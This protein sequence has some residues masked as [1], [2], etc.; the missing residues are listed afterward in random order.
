MSTNVILLKPEEDILEKCAELYFE[1]KETIFVFPSRRSGRYLKKIIA[2]KYKQPFIPPETYSIEEWILK[3]GE[4]FQ[5]KR[6]LIDEL[7]GS[8][9]IEKIIRR[10]GKYEEIFGKKY[11]TFPF[12]WLRE[13]YTLFEELMKNGV[14]VEDVQKV[15]L[16]DD[17]KI[18]IKLLENLPL[19]YHSYLDYL[20]EEGLT[21][22]GYS[23]Y[24]LFKNIDLLKIHN[25]IFAGLYAPTRVETVILKKSLS[26]KGN[27]LLFQ[28]TNYYDPLLEKVLNEMSV[29]YSPSNK[30]LPTTTIYFVPNLFSQTDIV[31]EI[32]HSGKNRIEEW[33]D[34]VII[35]PE[36][37]MLLPLL[38]GALSKINSPF[39]ITMGYP[40]SRTSL[41][42]LIGKLFKIWVSDQYDKVHYLDFISVISSP[43]IKNL[44]IKEYEP[45][46]SRIFF[47]NLRQTVKD[48]NFLMVDPLKLLQPSLLPKEVKEKGLFL[49]EVSEIFKLLFYLPR[50]KETTIKY[51]ATK[52]IKILNIIIEKS[53]FKK[54]IFSREY[55]DTLLKSIEQLGRKEIATR[56]M[57]INEATKII[58]KELEN[59]SVPFS[60]TP[61]KGIQVMGLLE[62]RNLKFRRVI[63]LN[64][65]EDTLPPI[66]K[67]SPLLPATIRT[68]LNLTMDLD[69][70]QYH[71]LISKHHF[72]TLIES[73]KEVHIIVVYNDESLTSRYV[74]EILWK[75]ENKTKI[76]RYSFPVTIKIPE[77]KI[78]INKTASI[79]KNLLHKPLSPTLL[80]TYIECPLKFYFSFILKLEE[81]YEEYEQEKYKKHGIIAHKILEEAYKKVFLKGDPILREDKLEELKSTINDLSEKIVRDEFPEEKG[82]YTVR[83]LI[84]QEVMK[85][86]LNSFATI[87]ININKGKQLIELERKIEI[88]DEIDNT[89]FRLKGILDRLQKDLQNNIIEIIDYKTSSNSKNYKPPV[90]NLRKKTNFW[91]TIISLD[92]PETINTIEDDMEFR[93]VFFDTIKNIQLPLYAYL[94]R[95]H[96]ENISKT[97]ISLQIKPTFYFI[98][99]NT[100]SMALDLSPLS[101]SSEAELFK[102]RILST[103]IRSI[104]NPAIP[105]Y[106]DSL[107]ESF[108]SYCPYQ[109]ICRMGI[110]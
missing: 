32:L 50:D 76:K 103:L 21:T 29:T 28:T 79:I 98:R 1:N 75:Y 101:D 93:R 3:K 7:D 10:I 51:L 26:F 107:D 77:E 85:T 81:D 4:T 106:P 67:S 8:L 55:A 72:Y 23:Y 34:T 78:K 12:Y 108:C 17:N 54:Y 68:Q 62:A 88:E 61:L 66:A 99:E 30:D 80:N 57:K 27:I 14:E 36:P 35:V 83:A 86:K 42:S 19:I 58:R 84:L 18:K 43:L 70:F 92:Y 71:D 39:N 56:K 63:I 64:A 69:S 100:R 13:V 38:Q 37:S 109:T 89:K 48:N 33:N 15:Y 105:F 9:V 52:L 95:K 91:E 6:K 97:N 73:A 16:A 49:K 82:L 44:K 5:Q 40:I 46:I 90:L 20:R 11:D 102:N 53:P 104:L 59:T 24:I 2:D 31:R 87:D 22:I 74:E 25:T 110:E 45:V 94:Y 65:N 41:Y 47:Q 60:G 96:M